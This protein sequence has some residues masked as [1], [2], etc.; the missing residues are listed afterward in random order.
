VSKGPHI[1][2]EQF[3]PVIERVANGM[4]LKQSL[5]VAGFSYANAVMRI[6]GNPELKDMLARAREDYQAFRIDEMREITATMDDVHRARLMCDNI[7]WEAARISPKVYGDK[8]AQTHT[9]A[10]GGPIK[11]EYVDERPPLEDFLAEFRKAP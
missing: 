10:D 2:D 11:V 7:K 8:I 3:I 5:E 4:S 1:K 9:G 6:S